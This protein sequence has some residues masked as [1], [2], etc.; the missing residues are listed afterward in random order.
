MNLLYS[1]LGLPETGINKKGRNVKQKIYLRNSVRFP[2]L[3]VKL[4][5]S[6]ANNFLSSSFSEEE[7]HRESHL[8][9]LGFV[10]FL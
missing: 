5:T 9:D 6:I 10:I 3:F 8:L 2:N 7:Y 4:W 1:S